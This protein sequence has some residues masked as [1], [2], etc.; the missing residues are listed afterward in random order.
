M[1]VQL[2][3]DVD[4][5]RGDGSVAD[6]EPVGDL[7]VGEAVDDVADDFALA[8]AELLIEDGFHLPLRDEVGDARPVRLVLAAQESA[9]AFTAVLREQVEVVE[10]SRMLDSHA[11]ERFFVVGGEDLSAG[12]ASKS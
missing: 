8:I 7:A 2:V 10:L 6:A 1:D 3:I 12:R 9:E 4:E 11:H 5:V